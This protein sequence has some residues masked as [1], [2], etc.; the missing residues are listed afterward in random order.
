[1]SELHRWSVS[2]EFQLSLKEMKTRFNFCC[3]EREENHG[4]TEFC[5]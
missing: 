3:P 4:W 2:N 1:M 5:A